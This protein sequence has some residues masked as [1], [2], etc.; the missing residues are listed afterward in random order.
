M[1]T[2]N[3]FTP[4]IDLIESEDHI[5]L[6]AD[7]PGVDEKSVDIVVEHGL[8]TIK[9]YTKPDD[10]GQR[11][12]HQSEY[13]DGNYQRVVTLSTDVDPGGIRATVKNGVL[14]LRLPLKQTVVKRKIPITTD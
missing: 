6:L 3:V 8:L 11:T 1:A 13:R 10:T 2:R 12:V 7:L 14:R 5:T 4:K 9:G